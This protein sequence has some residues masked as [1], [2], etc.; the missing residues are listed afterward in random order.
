MI[1]LRKLIDILPSFFKAN[2]TYKGTG[3]YYPI[4]FWEDFQDPYGGAGAEID[5]TEIKINN[6]L[7][8]FQIVALIE[9]SPSVKTDFRINITGLK[10][11]YQFY[12][13]NGGPIIDLLEDG[14]YSITGYSGEVSDP[15]SIGFCIKDISAVLTSQIVITLLPE[16]DGKTTPGILERFLEVCGNYFADDITPVID[17]FLDIIDV[18]K[19]SDIY[20]NYI[21]EFLGSIPYSYGAIIKGDTIESNVTSPLSKENIPKADVRRVLKY[22]ISLYKI[23]GTLDFYNILLRMYGFVSVE[24]D[25]HTSQGGNTPSSSSLYYDNEVYYDNQNTY[26]SVIDCQGCS[27]VN[28]TITTKDTWVDLPA[29]NEDRLKIENR[30]FLLLNRF[31]PLNVIPFDKTNVTF[32]K[33]S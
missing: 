11:E 23:R 12:Y 14:D 20:L 32:K 30:I 15:T 13:D 26:D 33:T 3:E 27:E 17:N 28:L 24:T 18:D 6:F 31:R 22:A 16:G 7:G 19:A 25:D 9:N 5:H 21:W 2:D 8:D 1:N 4:D 10:P 29:D